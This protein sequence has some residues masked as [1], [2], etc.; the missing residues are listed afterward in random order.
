MASPSVFT[1]FEQVLSTYFPKRAAA[2]LGEDANDIT[3]E[4]TLASDVIEH[5]K[6][7]LRTISSEEKDVKSTTTSKTTK[8]SS[9]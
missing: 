8:Q 6:K 7:E 4:T 9:R 3:L 1:S 2:R 5:L